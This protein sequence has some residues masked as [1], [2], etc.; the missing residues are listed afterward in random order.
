M[1]NSVMRWNDDQSVELRDLLRSSILVYASLDIKYTRYKVTV[2]N[3]V[4][5]IGDKTKASLL[6]MIL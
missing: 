2:Y 4:F 5:K 3:R 1:R 6:A